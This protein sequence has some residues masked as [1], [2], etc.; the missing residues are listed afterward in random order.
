MAKYQYIALQNN[1][2]LVKGEIEASTPREARE[3]IRLLGFV[4]TKVYTEEISQNEILS[5][6]QN[7]NFYNKKINYLSLKDKI[8]FTSELQV[9]LLSGI[10]IL[11]ALQTIEKNAPTQK[12][13]HICTSL[14]EGILAGLTFAEALNRFY[15]NVFGDVYTGLIKAGEDSGQLDITLERLVVL[16]KK[17][18]NIKDKIT[19]ASIYPC[20][21]FLMLLG[22]LIIFAKFVFPAF[23]GVITDS[24]N[25]IPFF[26]NS[27]IKVM[28]FISNYWW[29]IIISFAG[30]IR[31]FTDL[32]KQPDI[33]RT[34]DEF[35]LKIPVVSDFIE[36]INLSNFMT[37]LYI[38][39]EAGIPI[40]PGL[41]LSSNIV[42]NFIIKEKIHNSLSLIKKG[43]QLS[44]ALNKNKAVPNAL[45]TLISTGEKAGML[46]K[47]LQDAAKVIDKKIDMTLEALT[48]LFEPVVMVIMGGF[49]LIIA[50]TFAQ[51]Y[52]GMLGPLF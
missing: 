14:R 34:F 18:E 27:V 17:Q 39:Y 32:I 6:L 25:E 19:S 26:A 13:R 8:S 41:E 40:M 15:H 28:N 4:P 21:L 43:K 22:V 29:L 10:P 2:K 36:Y 24:G 12:L 46:G 51:L 33:K 52:F 38:S 30:G 5:N 35:I 3:R 31:I 50:I 7:N 45:L 42:G 20:V 9:L 48:R 23:I 11:E 47:M 44:E 49:V 1:T 16:L 37:V